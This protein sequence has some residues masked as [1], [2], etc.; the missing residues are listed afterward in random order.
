MAKK[1]GN[2]KVNKI[3]KPNKAS[4]KQKAKKKKKKAKTKQSTELG[5]TVKAQAAAVRLQQAKYPIRKELEGLIKAA[6]KDRDDNKLHIIDLQ[7]RDLSG[8]DLSKLDLSYA[9]LHKA[10]LRGA[11]LTYT[12]FTRA[13]FWRADLTD[14]LV[15]GTIFEQ[16]DLRKSNWQK[17][18]L[19]DS[20]WMSWANLRGEDLRFLKYPKD[21]RNFSFMS[22]D[23]T[24]ANLAGVIVAH[25]GLSGQSDGRSH[26]FTILNRANLSGVSFEKYGSDNPIIKA[27]RA[28]GANCENIDF[29]K[30]YFARLNQFDFANLMG[31]N[32][33]ET[34]ISSGMQ[35]CV[36]LRGADL[37]NARFAGANVN[38]ML[39]AELVNDGL[40]IGDHGNVIYEEDFRHLDLSGLDLSERD[41]AGCNLGYS[42][43]IGTNLTD[44]DLSNADLEACDFRFANLTNTNFHDATIYSDISCKLFAAKVAGGYIETQALPKADSRYRDI[45]YLSPYESSDNSFRSFIGFDLSNRDL[46]MVD[47]AGADLRRANLSGSN[48][49]GVDLTNADLEGANLTGAILE[50]ANLTDTDLSSVN[51]TDA[52][53]D[54]ANFSNAIWAGKIKV[55]G[56]RARAAIGLPSSIANNVD[57]A[58]GRF[59]G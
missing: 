18:N 20:M 14:A 37:R 15:K 43:F 26:K 9:N 2:S 59:H 52:N 38:W 1:I 10:N 7:G 29:N 45:N 48:L 58:D 46:R 55:A 53:L 36:S 44:T 57:F 24:A 25:G 28:W 27:I 42:N 17:V 23:L 32:F 21:W 34:S 8:A 22:A 4:K 35:D 19:K 49:A 39:G 11:N 30:A 6:Q 13:N 54:R 5:A 33:R 50:E 16:A 51:L 47:F 12:K 56:A 40:M 41:L 3:K 31:A